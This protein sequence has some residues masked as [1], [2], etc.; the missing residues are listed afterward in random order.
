MQAFPFNE[1]SKCVNTQK[2]L[3]SDCLLDPNCTTKPYFHAS[4]QFFRVAWR[5]VYWSAFVLTWSFIPFFLR[6]LDNGYFTV[7]QKSVKAL[8]KSGIYYASLGAIGLVAI[9]YL[10]A[11]KQMSRYT[12]KKA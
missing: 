6:Y 7:K 9:I 8:K 1:N 3:Y 4:D 11:T 2:T 5:V 12:L 10:L